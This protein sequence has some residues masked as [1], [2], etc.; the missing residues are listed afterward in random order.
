MQIVTHLSICMTR[1]FQLLA[2][3]PLSWMQRAGW[4][5]GWLVWALSPRYRHHFKRNV[6]IAG[7]AWSEARAA[8]GATGVMLAELPW[9][10]RMLGSR[11]T[12]DC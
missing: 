9:P 8:V 2:R 1:L 11:R 4:C 3:L 10:H 5:M 12:S 7:V 6:A